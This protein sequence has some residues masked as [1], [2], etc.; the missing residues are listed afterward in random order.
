MADDLLGEDNL[1]LRFRTGVVKKGYDYWGSKCANGRLPSMHDIN[2]MEIRRLM[3]HVAI[4]D[5]KHEPEMNFHYPLQG[6]DIVEH[7]YSDHSG[8]WFSEIPHQK[9]PRLIRQYCVK[10]I[11]TKMPLLVNTPHVGPLSRSDVRLFPA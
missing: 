9:T 2:P 1:P 11:E 8:K 3:P 7:P 4:V 5:V 10:V 6:T